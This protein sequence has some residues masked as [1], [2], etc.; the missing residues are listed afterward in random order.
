MDDGFNT[1]KAN[2]TSSKMNDTEILDA[3]NSLAVSSLKEKP[4]N[5]N[6][7]YVVVLCGK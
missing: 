4:N 3:A 5:M 7:V 1:K 2:A 6:G